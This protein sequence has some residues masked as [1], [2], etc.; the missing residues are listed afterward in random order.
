[1]DNGFQAYR[2][3]VGSGGTWRLPL[4][5][6]Q[7]AA[8]GL[9]A[10]AAPTAVVAPGGGHPTSFAPAAAP[11]DPFDPADP[12][13]VLTWAP[14]DTTGLEP[15]D[16]DCY[17]TVGVTT[18][19]VG[20]LALELGPGGTP[21][22][23]F[24]G[25]AELH[26]RTGGVVRALEL[27]ADDVAA[28]LGRAATDARRAVARRVSVARCGKVRDDLMDEALA[29]LGGQDG[30]AFEADEDVRDFVAW[31]AAWRLAMGPGASGQEKAMR[32]LRDALQEQAA[33]ALGRIALDLPAMGPVRFG[34][35]AIGRAR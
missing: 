35:T 31:R 3:V 13:A 9:H 6:D 23:A 21:E 33:K 24:V 26:R 5:E 8:L 30:A 17:L 32:G 7:Q 16:Y 34:A 19:R 12:A 22:A 29:L 25:A 27:D 28:A 2:C 18:I 1:M 4:T 20:R 15:G 14:A 11:E 10:G